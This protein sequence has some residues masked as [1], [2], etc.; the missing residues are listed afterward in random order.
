MVEGHSLRRRRLATFG[1]LVILALVAAACSNTGA[2]SPAAATAAPS[3][4]ASQGPSEPPSAPASPAGSGPA[5]ATLTVVGDPHLAAGMTAPVIQCN[6]PDPSGV[7]INVVAA[8]AD[9][10]D[11]LFVRV[12]SGGYAVVI[13]AGSGTTATSREFQGTSVTGFDAARGAQLSGT[14]TETTKP[15][16]ATGSLPALTSVTGT[17][18]CGGQTAGSGTVHVTS[19]LPEGAVDADLDP[20]RVACNVDAAGKT[21]VVVVGIVPVA[22]TKT[23]FAATIL[24]NGGVSVYIA[25]PTTHLLNATATTSGTISG[26]GGTFNADAVTAPGVSPSISAHIAGTAVCGSAG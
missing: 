21:T 13:G 25:T 14:L 5:T 17:I 6:F 23:V 9:Q 15:G 7:V 24:P 22:S 4:V 16:T 12:G 20:I 19:T 11:H 1:A 18:N 2:A 8:S 3:S 26:Q 10:A